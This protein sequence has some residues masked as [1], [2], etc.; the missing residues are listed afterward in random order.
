M[1]SEFLIK[2]VVSHIVHDIRDRIELVTHCFSQYCD[3]KV[4][5]FCC[6]WRSISW[7]TSSW[8]FIKFCCLQWKLYTKKLRGSANYGPPC[9]L[10]V[11][12]M[13]LNTNHSTNQPLLAVWASGSVPQ[14]SEQIDNSDWY[15][16]I[17]NW[18]YMKLSDFQFLGH[19]TVHYDWLF[20]IKYICFCP[21]TNLASSL[22][23][24]LFMFHNNTA[25]AF[26]LFLCWSEHFVHQ[27]VWYW[28]LYWHN[29][30]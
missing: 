28:N 4:W 1:I 9:S 8:N 26:V 22:F 6:V 12:K 18:W 16:I 17:L 5:N 25:S 19:P 20:T 29:V 13:P 7:Y 23:W 27:S 24:S 2:C 14:S 21:V 10:F 3:S 11:L 30:A 15:W